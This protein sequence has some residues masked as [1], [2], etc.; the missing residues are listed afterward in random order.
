MASIHGVYCFLLVVGV[1]AHLATRGQDKVTPVEKVIELLEKLQGQIEEEGKKEATQY[2]KYS[3]F[4]KEQADNKLYAIEKSNKKIK[5]LANQIGV[6][7]AEIAE[8]NG[9]IAELATRIS[10]LEGEIKTAVAV[11]AKEHAGY[12]KEAADMNGAINA[13]VGA[14]KALKDS[15]A[16]LVDAKLDFVQIQGLAN[17]VLQTAQSVSDFHLS[18]AQL[19]ALSLL[20]EPGKP[21]TYEYQSNDIIATLQGLLVDFKQ[22]KKELD[23]GEFQLKAAFD[24]K[25]LGLENEKKFAEKEQT[26]KEEV[27]AMKSDQKHAAEEDKNEETNM[28]DADQSFMDVLTKACQTKA[29]DWDQRSKTRA[30]ELTAI[31]TALETLRSGVKPNWGANKKLVGFTQ[32]SNKPKGHWVWEPDTSFLQLHSASS[33]PQRAL[34][35]LDKAAGRL[36]SSILTSIVMK[37]KVSTSEDHFVKVRGLIKDLIE[38]LE[39]DAK[40]EATQKSFCDGAMKDATTSRDSAQADVESLTAKLTQLEAEKAETEF[41]ISVLSEQ[42]AE[43]QKA[44]N[45]AIQLRAEERAANEKTIAEAG[46]GKD[47]VEFALT[48]LREFYDGAAGLVQYVPPDSDRE[49]NTVGDLAPEAFEGH[50]HGKQSSSKGIIGI[51][52]V[53]LSD[54]ERTVDTVT[55]EEKDAQDEF[56]QFEAD[57]KKDI[58]DKEQAKTDKEAKLATIKDDIADT[59]DKLIDAK[60]AHAGALEELEKL[61]AMCVEGEETYAERVAKREQE[62]E[63]LKE[64]LNI[65]E[66]WQA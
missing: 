26:E 4:C 50:Y 45:E 12:L 2:D 54:F 63:A 28:R 44:L 52:E 48:V 7:D 27:Q 25:K 65:L 3:C 31:A 29:Q 10:E 62:I 1:S 38:K 40:S 11:R 19:R 20:N 18:D 57:T 13:L 32:R 34:T 24:S 8:L 33:A 59:T 46:E 23:E 60:K 41:D 43:L 58:S 14:I 15:K 39:A 35:L 22:M 47:A 56:D 53:I 9:D 55:Q 17:K 42:I 51:L 6:L 21:A 49:G 16:Q 36:K 66:T 30:D 61:T 5:E 64:A 37:M